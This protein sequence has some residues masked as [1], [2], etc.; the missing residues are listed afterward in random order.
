LKL[1][2]EITFLKDSFI[3]DKSCYCRPVDL[4]ILS[5]S[6]N[7]LTSFG[8]HSLLRYE[9]RNSMTFSIESRVPF[10]DFRLV[11]FCLQQADKYKIRYGI[12]KYLLRESLKELLPNKIYKRND[13]NGFLSPQEIWTRRNMSFFISE[14]DRAIALNRV[15]FEDDAFKKISDLLKKNNREAVYIAWKIICFNKWMEVFKV[16]L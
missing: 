8:L 5:C 13:K 9:D 16:R 6:L 15:I 7:H 11:E 2:N 4:S 10:L 14:L 12:R 3:I 1:S